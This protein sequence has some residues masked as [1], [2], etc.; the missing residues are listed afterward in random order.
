MVA[1][2]YWGG[3]RVSEL[4][5]LCPPDVDPAAGTIR[6]LHGKGDRSRT[7]AMDATGFVFLDAWMRE[8]ARELRA[9]PAAAAAPPIFCTRAGRGLHASYA[10]TLLHRLGRRAG[11]AKRVHPN[12]LRISLAVELAQEGRDL[13]AIQQ[14]LG[15]ARLD[16]TA[17][18][19]HHKFPGGD[20]GV[21]HLGRP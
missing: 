19:L 1:L 9:A 14:F 15:Y 10:R 2:L 6:V 16:S 20:R 7:V 13:A 12:G 5:A 8:R 18:Y 11:I 17:R 3:L 21:C 4:L